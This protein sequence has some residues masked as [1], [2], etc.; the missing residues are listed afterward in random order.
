MVKRK[1]MSV[2][3][4]ELQISWLN[5]FELVIYTKKNVQILNVDT[6]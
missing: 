3:V 6:Y 4:N 1:Y 2:K 5:L